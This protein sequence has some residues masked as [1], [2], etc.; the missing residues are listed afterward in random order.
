MEKNVH[1]SV[2]SNSQG[3]HEGTGTPV[4]APAPHQPEQKLGSDS[5]FFCKTPQLLLAYSWEALWAH[6][7]QKF[8][9]GPSD[10]SF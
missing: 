3:A 1:C 9:L 5:P 8:C 2:S 7:V 6:L 10:T 4:E